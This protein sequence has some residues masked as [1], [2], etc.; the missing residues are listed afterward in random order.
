MPRP[1]PRPR[2]RRLLGALVLLATLAGTSAVGADSTTIT[3]TVTNSGVLAIDAPT[4]ASGTAE[5]TTVPATVATIPVSGIVISDG[6][7]LPGVFTATATA[8]SL[9]NGGQTIPNTGMVWATTSATSSGGAAAPGV[10]G[11]G[12]PLSASAVVAVGLGLGLGSSSYTVNGTITVPVTGAA[13]G[14][15]TGTLTTSIS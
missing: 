6:R 2:P 8:T 15:Y 3:L 5:Y 10:I 4:A 13:P 1:R 11:A 14:E 7:S 9:S 12:G